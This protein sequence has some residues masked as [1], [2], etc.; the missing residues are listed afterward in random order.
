MSEDDFDL[1]SSW[2]LDS[3]WDSWALELS[4]CYWKKFITIIFDNLIDVLNENS[5]SLLNLLIDFFVDVFSPVSDW[6][7]TCCFLAVKDDILKSSLSS[8][9]VNSL[10]FWSLCD[11]QCFLYVKCWMFWVLRFCS[12]S[13]L[14]FDVLN[15]WFFVKALVNL[16]LLAVKTLLSSY[17]DFICNLTLTDHNLMN[18]ELDWWNYLSSKYYVWDDD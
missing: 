3:F 11:I 13:D 6:V 2:D 1:E 4:S 15:T 12:L 10:S 5:S 17:Q 16:N 9:V 14:S 7:L 8:S 18:N